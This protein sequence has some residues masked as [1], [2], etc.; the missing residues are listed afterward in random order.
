MDHLSCVYSF[1]WVENNFY[2]GKTFTPVENVQNTPHAQQMFKD[3][4]KH[5]LRE[6]CR[7]NHHL[8]SNILTPIKK[9]SSQNWEQKRLGSQLVL[10]GVQK[11]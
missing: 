7:L 4:E 9:H 3:K 1:S 11:R 8:I 10:R 2:Y 5:I 6:N